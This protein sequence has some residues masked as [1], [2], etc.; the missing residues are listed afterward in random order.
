MGKTQFMMATGATAD[1]GEITD[2]DGN[3]FHTPTPA[4]FAKA[5]GIDLNVDEQDLSKLGKIGTV[6][7]LDDD[8]DDEFDGGGGFLWS[9]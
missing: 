7:E 1:T 6:S 8:D 2:N 5:Q 3:F 4:E 9:L